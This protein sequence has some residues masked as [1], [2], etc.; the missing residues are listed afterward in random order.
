[1]AAWMRLPTEI[2]SMA[3]GSHVLALQRSQCARFLPQN[4]KLRLKAM[5]RNRSILGKLP[6]LN[7][8]PVS[9]LWIMEKESPLSF[10]VLLVGSIRGWGLE[11]AKGDK[12]IQFIDL[13]FPVGLLKICSETAAAYL[14]KADENVRGED[15]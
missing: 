7:I 13:K 12:V 8:L 10:F 6:L 2:T 15:R 11:L 5:S 3:D 9:E 1:M 4:M 14:L